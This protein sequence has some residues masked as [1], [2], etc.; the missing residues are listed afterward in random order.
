MADKTT[1]PDLEPMDTSDVDRWIGV[2]VGGPVLKDP[3]TANDIRRWAQ[4][5]QN[6]TSL[7]YDDEF[8]AKSAYRNPGGAAVL[9]RGLRG[10]TR[11]ATR[12]PGQRFPAPTCCSA[13]MSGGFT[14]RA[15]TPATSSR[16][17]ACCSTTA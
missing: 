16:A 8:A 7:F 1:M 10:W 14:D 13:A 4:A 17:N 9:L 2:P 6:P 15:S 11:G 12:Y 3:I 5:M